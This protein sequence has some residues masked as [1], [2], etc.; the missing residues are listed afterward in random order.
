MGSLSRDEFFALFSV[1]AAV[2]KA[3]RDALIT[4][5]KR[6]TEERLAKIRELYS[7]L[8]V[9]GREY[10]M[11]PEESK[12][13]AELRKYQSEYVKTLIGDADYETLDYLSKKTLLQN[14]IAAEV[15]A[16]N[17]KLQSGDFAETQSRKKEV[18]LDQIHE[19][20][21]YV[22]LPIH[23]R[24]MASTDQEMEE[25]RK[26][27]IFEQETLRNSISAEK[28]ALEAEIAAFDGRENGY[29]SQYL[30]DKESDNISSITNVRN[31][32]IAN[33]ARVLEIENLLVQIE[34][35]IDRLTN[36]SLEAL[37]EE[38]SFNIQKETRLFMRDG[39]D[40]KWNLSE[41]EEARRRKRY[42]AEFESEYRDVKKRYAG[43]LENGVNPLNYVFATVANDL[44]KSKRIL[45][46]AS[47]YEELIAQKREL[48]VPKY[49][50][51]D[52]TNCYIVAFADTVTSVA[53]DMSIS[54]TDTELFW[55]WMG[56]D[57]SASVDEVNSA[58]AKK[59]EEL[60]TIDAKIDQVYPPLN[61]K[62]NRQQEYGRNPIVV[63]DQFLLAV[64]QLESILPKE[65]YDKLLEDTTTYL[66]NQGR[67]PIIGV[68]AYETR[69][70]A[71]KESI[72]ERY[73]AAEKAH[74]A[75]RSKALF[76]ERIAGFIKEN[77]IE[78]VTRNNGKSAYFGL[79]TYGNIDT[80]LPH[81]VLASTS[82]YESLLDGF[83]KT[84]EKVKAK[85]AEEMKPIDLELE[86]TLREINYISELSLQPS[87]E[88]L[89]PVTGRKIQYGEP[90]Y[91]DDDVIKASVSYNLEL[92]IA[93]LIEK[94]MQQIATP[95]LD[96][97]NR[98]K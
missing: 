44:S 37:R 70:E 24:M 90:R 69:L 32:N 88:S 42:E 9:F 65:E 36:I 45:E 71:A 10:E 31:K 17:V 19:I 54:A 77:N 75:N 12:L 23:A 84:A 61:V 6:Y 94:S 68:I 73:S 79:A 86:S 15:K 27:L 76:D 39:S 64:K 66:K 80:P 1:E 41:D 98:V 87:T 3:E 22:L 67:K 95:D 28:A 48:V 38:M 97:D 78:P 62:L 49:E 93:K 30:K 33:K 83:E 43:V 4:E 56:V 55:K 26:R 13:A 85:N 14:C 25:E 51:Y 46:P 96:A 2:L 40:G 11:S 63:D 21:G 35:E 20:E 57:K 81:G 16:I 59:I 34:K 29:I 60:R 53:Q 74:S 52:F 72:L 18:L 7:Q 47:K 8:S 58:I 91:N 92:R 5:D 50:K 89:F 82:R